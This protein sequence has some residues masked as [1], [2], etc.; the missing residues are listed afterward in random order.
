MTVYAEQALR[1]RGPDIG[2]RRQA[3]I[4][5]RGHGRWR[6]TQEIR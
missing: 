5:V 6:L 2:Q 4:V 1:V 3:T